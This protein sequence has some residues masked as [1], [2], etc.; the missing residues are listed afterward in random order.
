MKRLENKDPES[1]FDTPRGLYNQWPAEFSNCL[2][3]MARPS[4]ARP[5][6]EQTIL[7]KTCPHAGSRT[8]VESQVAV[9]SSPLGNGRDSTFCC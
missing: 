7:R 6:R 1:Y 5:G 9:L 8:G 4:G 3:K 2:N